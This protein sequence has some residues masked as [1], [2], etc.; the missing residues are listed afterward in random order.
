MINLRKQ[1]R[2]FV[3][4]L[5]STLC[6]RGCLD[7]G[8]PQ[9]LLLLRDTCVSSCSCWSLPGPTC[10]G[11]GGQRVS[12]CCATCP[13]QPTSPWGPG[14]PQAAQA[15]Q[16]RSVHAGASPWQ[17]TGDLQGFLRHPSRRAWLRGP[18]GSAPA[19]GSAL[20]QHRQPPARGVHGPGG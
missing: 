1:R 2:V 13:A 10:P 11:Q 3:L 15:P 7:Q 20:V 6:A 17:D 9:S 16:A 14:P 5:S 19:Q 12:P 4:K 18:E 8:L